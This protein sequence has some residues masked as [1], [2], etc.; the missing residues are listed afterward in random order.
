MSKRP[1]TPSA[2]ATGA[3]MKQHA[4]KKPNIQAH[5]A[6]F[7]NGAATSRRG[8]APGRSFVPHPEQNEA[9]SGI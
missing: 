2:K 1:A 4:E 3:G 9:P 5:V 6:D 8:D 7:E